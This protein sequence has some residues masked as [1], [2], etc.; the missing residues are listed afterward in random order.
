M[1]ADSH[2]G[3]GFSNLLKKQIIY[4]LASCLY[5]L[6]TVYQ[7][8]LCKLHS[9]KWTLKELSCLKQNRP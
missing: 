6:A 3:D 1:V 9:V 8:H 7:I 2:N 5:A 4:R